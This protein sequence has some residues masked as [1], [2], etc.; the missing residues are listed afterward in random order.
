MIVTCRSYQSAIVRVAVMPGTAQAK[1]DSSG[2]KARPDSPTCPIRLSSNLG[3]AGQGADVGLVAAGSL[4]RIA[5]LRQL[6]QQLD[7][8]AVPLTAAV[9]TTAQPSSAESAGRS[10]TK[11]RSRAMSLM[12][13]A[14]AIGCTVTDLPA[15][16]AASELGA[17]L[18]ELFQA[19]SLGLLINAL[20]SARR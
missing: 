2:R 1:L 6:Y 20:G 16:G 8:A 10:M 18:R 13:S 5:P 19:S 17:L 11:P 4:G 15:R 3:Q 7:V 9:S 14:A 12:V